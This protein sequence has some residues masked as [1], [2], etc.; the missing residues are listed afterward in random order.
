[1]RAVDA[2]FCLAGARR[3]RWFGR[4]ACGY[5]T[6]SERLAAVGMRKL[7]RRRPPITQAAEY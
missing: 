2:L 6:I 1:M 7:D 3:A 5:S 4:R